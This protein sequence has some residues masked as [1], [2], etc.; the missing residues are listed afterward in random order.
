MKRALSGVLLCRESFHFYFEIKA[1]FLLYYQRYIDILHI[2]D[3]KIYKLEDEDMGCIEMT[4]FA[5]DK[6]PSI[7][8]EMFSVEEAQKVRGVHSYA[9]SGI[10]ESF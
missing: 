2:G 6:K 5:S 4:K 3:T 1:C 10:E 9:A 8:R 7:Y